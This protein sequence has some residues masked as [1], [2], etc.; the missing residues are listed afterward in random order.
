[1]SRPACLASLLTSLLLWVAPLAANPVATPATPAPPP[2]AVER[3][4]P[5][6]FAPPARRDGE[7]VQTRPASAPAPTP[8][9]ELRNRRRPGADEPATTEP[10]QRAPRPNRTR[11]PRDEEAALLDRFLSL[12]PEQLTQARQTIERIERMSPEERAALRERVRAQREAGDRERSE[13][14]R[15]FWSELP[16]DQRRALRERLADFPPRE[17]WDRLERLRNTPAPQREAAI[18]RMLDETPN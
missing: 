1:M 6:P 11:E 3:E 2:P 15:Q 7:V 5:P 18:K 13:G 4:R 14:A 10:R 17:R 9:P 12:P 16:P 8:A